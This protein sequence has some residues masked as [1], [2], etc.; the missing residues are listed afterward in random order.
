[1]LGVTSPCATSVTLMGLVLPS[2]V[3]PVTSN[4]LSAVC[5]SVPFATDCHATVYGGE[6]PEMVKL[7]VWDAAALPGVLTV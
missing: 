2:L 7:A 1:M 5:V 4:L 6:P 3:I